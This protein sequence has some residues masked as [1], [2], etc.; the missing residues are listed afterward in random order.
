MRELS[1]IYIYIPAALAAFILS[2]PLPVRAYET[3]GPDNDYLEAG[4]PE[5]DGTTLTHLPEACV[6][7]SHLNLPRMGFYGHCPS[8]DGR[9]GRTHPRPCVSEKY[10]RAV[11][12]ALINVSEC[13]GYDPRL[14]YATFNLESAMHLNAVGR[15]TDVGV[16][17]LT[18]VGIDE[19]NLNAFDRA[20]R[21]VSRSHLPACALILPMMSKHPSDIDQRCGFIS[22][23]ENPVRNL[24]YSVLLIQQLRRSV[25][26][27]W[28]RLG[29]ALP[30]EI[31]AER[32][33]RLMTM[34]SYNAGPGGVM[35]TLKGY[36]MQM[37]DQLKSR[38]FDFEST[39]P[40]SFVRY[41]RKNFPVGE[42]QDAVR[43]RVSQ[44]L[45][46]VLASVRRID[47]LAGG[48][49][50]APEVEP[51][52][53][54]QQAAGGEVRTIQWDGRVASQLVR[55]GVI[56]LTK[57][58]GT[59]GRIRGAKSCA[60]LKHDLLFAFSPP[61]ARVENLPSLVLKYYVKVCPNSS[62]K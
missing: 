12:S 44:Y 27:Y 54:T 52:P 46:H 45:K 16:G 60:R 7:R 1:Y 33:K 32:V 59:E 53:A 21:Q 2:L 55:T 19:V 38:H 8:A 25:D 47:S 34:L 14:A 13:L 39:A 23:P 24:I 41:L 42:G 17:Q 51:L 31:N 43:N 4:L 57:Y 58:I 49:C 37:G 3:C 36:S 20:Y 9:P 15:A 50:L 62:A 6:E 30:A 29:I 40:D 61:E 48:Q 35:A 28:S 26:V 18:R 10:V 11:H 56:D 5:P 22:S